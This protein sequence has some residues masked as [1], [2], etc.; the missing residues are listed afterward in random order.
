MSLLLF[1][2]WSWVPLVSLLAAACSR[3]LVCENARYFHVPEPNAVVPGIAPFSIER[4]GPEVKSTDVEGVPVALRLKRGTRV[5]VDWGQQGHVY[6]RKEL[7]FSPGDGIA[8]YVDE[9][10]QEEVFPMKRFTEGALERVRFGFRSR[11]CPGGSCT[12]ANPRLFLVAEM[13][14]HRE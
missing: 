4:L 7:I 2:R 11:D 5:A 10:L 13:S 3:D 8:E 14:C 12:N 6:G 9:A 1:R